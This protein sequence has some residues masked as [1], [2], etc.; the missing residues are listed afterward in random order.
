MGLLFAWLG[1][2][3]LSR[4]EIMTYGIA[5]GTLSYTVVYFFTILSSTGG[6]LA[7]AVD[8]FNVTE[9]VILGLPIVLILLSRFDSFWQLKGN[10]SMPHCSTKSE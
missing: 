5:C 7:Q 8:D 9:Y 3:H 4:R 2:R 10:P 1:S 6:T